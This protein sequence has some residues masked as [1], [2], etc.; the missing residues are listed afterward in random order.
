MDRDREP[1]LERKPAVPRDV[2]GVGM[3]L[4]D[5]LDPHACF[6]GDGQDLFDRER[7]ID[8]DG[9]TGLRVADEVRRT[10]QILVHEL[11][12]KQHGS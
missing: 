10:S 1:V 8:H 9:D 7:R 6:F 11:P 12:K 5:A 2:V 4:E 3:R